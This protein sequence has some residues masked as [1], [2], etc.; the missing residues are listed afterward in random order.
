MTFL[1]LHIILV[2]YSLCSFLIPPGRRIFNIK[3]SDLL[4]KTYMIKPNSWLHFLFLKKNRY[5]NF[6]HI[7]QNAVIVLSFWIYFL[8]NSVICSFIMYFELNDIFYLTLNIISGILMGIYVSIVIITKCI[9][10]KQSNEL[11]ERQSK[12]SQKD[13]DDLEKE[14]KKAKHMAMSK[15]VKPGYK[16]KVKNA[17][18]KVKRKHRREV[19]RKDIRRQRVERYKKAA[20]EE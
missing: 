11:F 15:N 2:L 8:I 4:F 3:D 17:I 19:I 12:L 7:K 9:L 1:I 20:S 16:K 13:H 14:I 5:K 10:S 18:D 6:L